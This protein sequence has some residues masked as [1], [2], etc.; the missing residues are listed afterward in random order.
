MYLPASSLS[1]TGSVDGD[2]RWLRD[3]SCRKLVA[4]DTG[5]ERSSRK[6]EQ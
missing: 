2:I 3:G 4:A 5:I 1:V 6:K